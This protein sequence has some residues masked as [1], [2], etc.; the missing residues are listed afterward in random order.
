MA[1]KNFLVYIFL[2][3]PFFLTESVNI[4]ASAIFKVYA[5]FNIGVSVNANVSVGIC[6]NVGVNDSVSIIANINVNIIVH[7]II[8]I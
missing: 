2:L 4:S 1:P 8:N 5:D 6:V 7:I 3:Y